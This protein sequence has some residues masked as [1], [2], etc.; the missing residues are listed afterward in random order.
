MVS[1][2]SC[3]VQTGSES[4]RGAAAQEGDWATAEREPAWSVKQWADGRE[5]GLGV[6]LAPKGMLRS[7]H[8][9]GKDVRRAFGLGEWGQQDPHWWQLGKLTGRL[10][11]C[12]SFGERGMSSWDRETGRVDRT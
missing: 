11:G 8:G 9:G 1:G 3:G 12:W 6:L 7:S 2:G 4:G 10:G 5:R